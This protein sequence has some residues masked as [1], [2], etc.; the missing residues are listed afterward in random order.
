[1]WYAPVSLVLWTRGHER[2]FIGVCETQVITFD[3]HGIS[4]HPNHCQLHHGARYD[5]SE[6][7][8]P[9]LPLLTRRCCVLCT[10]CEG[11]LAHQ[12]L[13]ARP[14]FLQLETVH[15]VRKY[16]GVLDALGTRL[17]TAPYLFLVNG[18]RAAVAGMRAHAS[19]LV[20]FRRLYL[21]FSRYLYINTL[22]PVAP[23]PVP[24]KRP[25]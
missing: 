16:A 4:G 23:L 12:T 10:L 20:W 22:R 8:R 13:G 18:A 17:G 1:M 21:V 24:A 9:P 19:Q 15:L 14:L 3:E 5:H 6:P 2:V 25:S 11:R 7:L